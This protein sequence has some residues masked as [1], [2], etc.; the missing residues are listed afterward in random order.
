MGG[1]G[2]SGATGCGALADT[3][4]GGASLNWMTEGAAN[5]ANDVAVAPSSSNFR[6]NPSRSVPLS[7]C[8]VWIDVVQDSDNHVFFGWTAGGGTIR[9]ITNTTNGAF[10]Q[11]A[12]P[13]MGFMDQ[14]LLDNTAFTVGRIRVSAEAG[15]YRVE[16]RD[17]GSAMWR[18]RLELTDAMAPWLGEPDGRPVFGLEGAGIDAHFDN[19]GVL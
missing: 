8:S 7:D 5:F 2:G 16:T 14:T 10:V 12:Q 15:T 9:F 3:F 1:A 18:V 17:D 19:F 11:V 4:D 13:G 6:L